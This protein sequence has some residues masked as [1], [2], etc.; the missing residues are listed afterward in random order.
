MKLT[1]KQATLLVL[2]ALVALAP[3]VFPSNFYYT[4]WAP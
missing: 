4:A 3:L 2:V 1:A